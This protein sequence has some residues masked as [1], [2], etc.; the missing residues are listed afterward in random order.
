MPDAEHTILLVD[1]EAPILRALQR[2]FRRE[3]YQI[4]TAEG[5]EQALALLSDT[6]D[7]VSLII[8]DQRMPGMNGARFLELSREVAP[9]A[10]RF[11]LT[12]YSDLDAVVASIN[13]GE[14]QRYLTKPWNDQ[15]L[16]LQVRQAIEQVELR[17]ENHRLLDLTRQQNTELQAFNLKLE[18]KVEARTK[19]IRD[20]N[21]KLSQANTALNRSLV[22]TVRLLA[23]LVQTLNPFLGNQMK[24]TAKLAVQLGRRL[25]LKS[26]ALENIELAAMIHD[27]GLIGGSEKLSRKDILEVSSLEITE[28]RQHPIVG[29]VCLQN[30]ERMAPVADIILHHHEAFD[31]SGFP[32]GLQGGDIPLGARIIGPVSDYVRLVQSW[33]DNVGKIMARAKHLL[34]ATADE[35]MMA[36]RDELVADLNRKCLLARAPKLYDPEIVMAFIG[37]LDNA[38]GDAGSGA[39]TGSIRHVHYEELQA[40][41][42][43]AMEIRTRDGRFVLPADSVLNQILLKS[44]QR[45]GREAAIVETVPVMLGDR[46]NG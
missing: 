41:M 30:M 25:G 8:S 14:I 39:E 29:S 37:M 24:D 11:L 44:L 22:D 12:G 4:L 43:I 35:I 18:K 17:R 7:P 10:I 3:G 36:E 20:K 23:S 6:A 46:S 38:S 13:R 33:P 34:G 9:D 2:L 40:G 31:G 28:Y 42:R 27:I 19:T 5:G 1:D 21:K 16:L 32:A 15:D 26:D 45:L